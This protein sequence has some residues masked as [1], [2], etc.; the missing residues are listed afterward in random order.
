MNDFA[1]AISINPKNV[2]EVW[3]TLREVA[4]TLRLPRSDLRVGV[5]IEAEDSRAILPGFQELLVYLK[6]IFRSVG[7]WDR[8]FQA[9]IRRLWPALPFP[10]KFSYADVPNK[11]R[12]MADIGDFESAL[13]LDAGTTPPERFPDLI[14]ELCRHLA[15]GKWGIST[16]YTDRTTL[17]NFRHGDPPESYL[18]LV[19]AFTTIDPHWGR[20]PAGLGA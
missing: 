17:R 7:V 20:A 2:T 5:A 3:T 9:A 10:D 14:G 15:S 16:Y 19:E 18:N 12:V 11:S 1:V 4:R 13:T 6:R 8:D